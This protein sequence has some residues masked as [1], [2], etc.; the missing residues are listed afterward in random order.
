MTLPGATRELP[1]ALDRQRAIET[2]ERNLV[3]T[4]G[5]GTG[6]TTLL[7]DRLTRLL[8]RNPD[9]LKI[10]EIVALTFTNKAANEMKVRLRER[11][12]AYLD[13]TLDTPAPDEK[14]EKTQREVAALIRLNQLSKDELDN[15]VHD[16]LRNL[17]RA[18]IGTIHSFAA[19]LL[20]LYPLEAGVDPHFQE[21]DG[22]QFSRIFGEQWALWLDQELSTTSPHAEGWRKALRQLSI[23]Q[24]RDLASALCSETVEVGQRVERDDRKQAHVLRSWLAGLL[25]NA[26]ALIE[27]HPEERVNEKV[28]RA[29]AVIIEEVLNTGTFSKTLSAEQREFLLNHSI[30][31]ATQGWSDEDAEAAQHIVRVAKA[32]CRIDAE[33]TELVWRLLVPYVETFRRVFVQEGFL[34]FDGLLIRSR[35]LVRD[36][37]RVREELKRQFRSILIDEFQ[38]TDPIQYEILLYLAERPGEA[39][40]D[41]RQI[42]LT[43]GKVF[44]VGDPKQSIYAF[45]RADI[46]AYLEVVENIIKAQDGIESRLTANFRSHATI[47]DVVNGVFESL[48]QAQPGMQP[49]YI[50][51]EPPPQQMAPRPPGPAAKGLPRVLVRKIVVPDAEVNAE[52]ARRLEGE[53]LSRWLRDDVL[54]KAR[55]VNAEGEAV[56]VQPKD[57]AILFRKLT[58][59]QDY[60]EPLRRRGIRYVVEG[61]RHFYAA[62]EVID[63]VNLLRA[64]EN[65]YDRLAL[66]GVL[67]SPLGA[68][69]DQEIY[70]LRR[71]HLLDYR[72]AERLG[73]TNVPPSLTELYCGLAELHRDCQ[74]LPVG[75]AGA[76]IFARF[77]LKPLA[78]CYFHG[79][80]AVANLEKLR[81]QAEILGREDGAM[82]FKEAVRQLQKRVLDVRE[83]GE[84]V[85]AEENVDAVRIMSIH[86]AKGLE[87]P[88]VILGGCQT[89]TDTRNSGGAE[90][91]FDWSSGLTGVRIGP[92]TDL[93]GVYIA[94]KNRL[95]AEEEQ[96]RV[97]YVAMT[98]AR[99]HLVISTAVTD[100][101]SSGNFVSLLDRALENQIAAAVRP[102]VIQIGA[103]KLD[104]EIVETTFA[105]PGR[106]SRRKKPRG[107]AREW[108]PYL[109]HWSR[110]RNAYAAALEE[111][112]FVTPTLLKARE[113][114]FAEDTGEIRRAAHKD[115]TPALLVGELAHRFLEQWD[116]AAAVED[117]GDRL[118]EFIDALLPREA[119]QHAAVIRA[120]LET[121]L[122]RFAGCDVYAELTQARILGRE[123][124]LLMPWNDRVMEGVID[125]VYERNGL[126]Y[127]ADYKTD[128]ITREELR[129]ATDR[130]QRQAEIYSEAARRSLGRDIAAFKLIFLSLGETV[131]VQLNADQQLRLW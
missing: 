58:D 82:T 57:V 7:V 11:L 88:I 33:M 23:E 29:G 111:P 45:R 80:Q 63:A 118:G 44:V 105:A 104:V 93:A 121:I 77:P 117:L 74:T 49:S 39:A 127:L 101:S 98:R 91:M 114:E 113:Q 71:R 115:K 52:K 81:Q 61:E 125:L 27:R 123:V 40:K 59:I 8:L 1:D 43:P 32:L 70:D 25:D 37:P 108:Q 16:S 65:P 85:L 84:S 102:G 12:Q 94:E 35:N 10:T 2:F 31:R 128:R 95:R 24:I 21:D 109:A 68:L 78:A 50:G 42:K 97:L 124:P 130:Y 48:I 38:D 3:V 79:E 9:P 66:V 18:N 73:G 6:K 55:I 41:W 14:T 122:Q 76:R 89:G 69:T 26:T 4:A 36:H 60:L 103:G 13:V 47:L 112:V 99:E 30:N 53:S 100:K 28:L 87:F 34:S 51:I 22:G 90:V 19:A 5:A 92:L 126:L 120:E 96:K 116:F 64:I 72:R 54:D 75:D 131:D 62:K 46:E 17:E 129:L 110:R 56:P 86:K 106:T 67:R 15:R 20:R 107:T 119:R 83:E